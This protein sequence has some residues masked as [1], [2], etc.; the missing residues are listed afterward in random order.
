MF[1][2]EALLFTLLL[3]VLK[4]FTLLSELI[5][6]LFFLDFL[7]TFSFFNFHE[8][9][10]RICEVCAHLGDLLLA[11]D[12][13]LLLALQVFLSLPFDELALEHLLFELLDEADFEVLELLADVFGVGLFELVL[14]LELSA[15]LLVVL[16]HLLFLDLDP[17]LFNF[18]LLR[19]F[20]R[21]Q[22]LLSFLLVSHVAHHHFTL[23]CLNHVLVIMHLLLCFINSAQ[24]ELRLIFLFLSVLYS[25]GNLLTQ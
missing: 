5:D 3:E 10:V 22:R 17:V 20:P 16:F 6:L 4:L 25:S 1:V 14:L 23:Q 8:F 24:S 15:H 18:F 7:K 13:A 2:G 11:L 19:L 12:F 21:C 9:L